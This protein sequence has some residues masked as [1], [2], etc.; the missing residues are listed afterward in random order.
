VLGHIDRLDVDVVTFEGAENNG[1]E[2]PDI[3]AAISRNKKIAIG[4]VSHRRLQV[5][6]PEEVA[7]LIRKAV[8]LIEPERLIVSTDCGFGRQGIT[9][10]HAFFKM[11]ALVKGT[12]IVRRELGLPEAPV[13][14]A[15]QR[16]AFL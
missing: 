6:T 12:N 10:A 13:A 8:K 2:F 9:R 3:A 16:L 15:D 5:E 14:A 4:A 1:L 7:A 11:V